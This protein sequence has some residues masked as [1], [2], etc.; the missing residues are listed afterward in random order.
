[1]AREP[2]VLLFGH[3]AVGVA[4]PEP[5]R[6]PELRLD[7]VDPRDL[8]CHGV[9]DLDPGIDLDE[10]ERARIGIH[11]E[12]DRAGIDVAGLVAEVEGVAA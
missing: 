11:Q 5:F 9:L 1:M 8:L 6:N 2:D 7:D 12:L 4:D 10:I 3:E